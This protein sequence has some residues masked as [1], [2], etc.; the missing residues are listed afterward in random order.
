MTYGQS[1]III[2]TKH[3]KSIRFDEQE[4]RA[5]GRPAKGVRGINLSKGDEVVGMEQAPREASNPMCCPSAKTAL[6][7]ARPLANTNASAA[8]GWA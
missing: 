8:A 2:A 6:V 7:N 4:A 3:G 1:D 5:M